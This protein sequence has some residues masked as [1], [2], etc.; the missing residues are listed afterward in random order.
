MVV[1]GFRRRASKKVLKGVE[2]VRYYRMD[3][4]G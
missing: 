2:G 3:G 4:S 1:Q